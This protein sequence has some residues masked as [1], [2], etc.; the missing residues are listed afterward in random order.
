MTRLRRTAICFPVIALVLIT[1]ASLQSTS[2]TTI[3]SVTHAAPDPLQS[4][5]V[6]HNGAV[7]C[8]DCTKCHTPDV[9]YE[10]GLY[11]AHHDLGSQAVIP[12]AATVLGSCVVT[13]CHNANDARYIT[14][15]QPSHFYCRTCHTSGAGGVEPNPNDCQACHVE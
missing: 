14:I 15:L 7:T 4:C 5:N 9:I 1:V 13:A 3:S 8:N 2:S 10:S 12:P 6:C 11:Q